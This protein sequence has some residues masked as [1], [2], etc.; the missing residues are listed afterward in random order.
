M[1][2]FQETM[3]MTQD[4]IVKELQDAGALLTGHFKLRSGK[5]SNRFFQCALVF[6]DPARGER[7]C[8]ELARRMTEQ[9]IKADTVISP[10][11]GGLFVGQ[12]IARALKLKSIFA[13]KVNDE[14]VLK[15]G[16]AIRPGERVIVAEDVVTEGGR[17][18]Q[19]I[20]LVRKLGGVPVAVAIITDRSGGKADFGLPLF[21]LLQLNLPTYPPEECP[22]CHDNIPLTTPGSG[23]GSK[24]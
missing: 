12:E 18:R 16:F 17:V 1:K 22:L 2:G 8:T 6:E 13:D 19:T 14:L 9:G 7:L 11:V 21:S 24:A 20:D 23:A 15:R 4:Q 10:A 3:A 5:H